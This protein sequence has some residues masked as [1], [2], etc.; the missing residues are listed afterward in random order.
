MHIVHCCCTYKHVCISPCNDR[1]HR[2]SYLHMCRRIRL[3]YQPH[4]FQSISCRKSILLPSLPV[5][6]PQSDSQCH[7]GTG[8]H[9]LHLESTFC[10]YTRKR[11]CRFELENPSPKMFPRTL[12]RWRQLLSYTSHMNPV[13]FSELL[14]QFRENCTRRNSLEN[15]VFS[16]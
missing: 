9:H 4:T 1:L 13:P 8:S 6:P 14:S 7:S 10:S 5:Y 16:C 2:F 15:Q 11:G 3:Y 12:D